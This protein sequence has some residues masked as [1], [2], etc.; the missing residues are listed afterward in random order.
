[1]LPHLG[2]FQ[3]KAFCILWP[4]KMDEATLKRVRK[5]RMFFFFSPANQLPLSLHK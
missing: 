1:M 4:V 2:K 5:G 3:Y